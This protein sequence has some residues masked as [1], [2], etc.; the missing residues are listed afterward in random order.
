MVWRE[1]VLTGNSSAD[2]E[3]QIGELQ[4]FLNENWRASV[5][6]E[7]RQSGL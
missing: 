1:V 6:A 3:R 5:S 7:I 2:F 4:P